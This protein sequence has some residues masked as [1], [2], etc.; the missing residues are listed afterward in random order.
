MLTARFVGTERVGQRVR[1][2]G[3]RVVSSVTRTLREFMV[4][5]QSYVKERKLER[6]T[7][8]HRRT[9]KLSRSVHQ[10]VDA[11]EA[12]IVGTLSAG[13]EVPYAKVHEYGGDVWI[14][15]HMR[16]NIV[17]VREVRASVS[18]GLRASAKSGEFLKT[19]A[20]GG[21]PIVFVRGY[22]AHYPERSFLRSSLAERLD[23]FR[24]AI[25]AAA[26]EGINAGGRGA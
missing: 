16:L 6:G 14:P 12:K 7:P 8:L 1:D 18:A 5:T 9:G 4:S 15:P 2:R 19:R 21:S 22:M 11:D 26:A 17:R 25:R 10:R 13:A 23:A 20:A 3:P 24:F